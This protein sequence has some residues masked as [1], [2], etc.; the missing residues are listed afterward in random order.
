MLSSFCCSLLVFLPSFWLSIRIRK[1]TKM[2]GQLAQILRV[3]SGRC[4][5]EGVERC[6]TTPSPGLNRFH[7]R[8]GQWG[9]LRSPTDQ[10]YSRFR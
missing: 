2:P 6:H 4:R 3:P 9:Q 10:K 5:T 1:L 8:P 7:W